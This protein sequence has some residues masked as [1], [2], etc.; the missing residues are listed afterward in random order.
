MLARLALLLSAQVIAGDAAAEPPAPPEPAALVRVSALTLVHLTM[1]DRVS[2]NEQKRGD[3]FRFSV[4]EDVKVQGRVVIPAGAEGVGEVVHAEKSSR[5]EHGELLLGARFVRV[6]DR[7]VRLRSF[8]GGGGDSR[9]HDALAVNADFGSKT[10]RVRGRPKIMGVNGLAGASTAEAVEL[11]VIARPVVAGQFSDD[12]P[13][14][15][16]TAVPSV[17]VHSKTGTVIFFR[18]GQ[19]AGSGVRYKVREGETELGKLPPG[20]YFIVTSPVGVHKFSVHSEA[21]D[22]LVLD[23]EPGETY[24]VNGGVTVGIIM[25]RPNL[26]PSNQ[27]VFDRLKEKLRDVTGLEIDKSAR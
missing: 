17:D 19:F 11:P 24:Y 14:A 15:V 12:E 9:V 6:G 23:V 22:D 5:H 3:R 25:G 10:D 27:G 4:T 26:A 20:G 21:A 13:A 8:F 18:E 2:S 1:V 16:A 7:E